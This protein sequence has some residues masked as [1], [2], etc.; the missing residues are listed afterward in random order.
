MRSRR[1]HNRERMRK[2]N[3]RNYPNWPDAWKF[4]DTRKVCSCPMCG[5][6]RRHFHESTVQERRQEQR[7]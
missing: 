7:T 2:R 1:R 3:R 4:G 5:N 6:P